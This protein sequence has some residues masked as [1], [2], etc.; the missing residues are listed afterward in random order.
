MLAAGALPS[1]AEGRDVVLV[2]MTSSRPP[3]ASRSTSSKN[4]TKSAA[5]ANRPSLPYLEEE[6]VRR[7]EERVLL[8]HP[9]P[10]REL[11]RRN[12]ERVL[13]RHPWPRRKYSPHW[14]RCGTRS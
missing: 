8:R 2:G 6:L 4:P 1:L 11:V 12:E 3:G 13:L 5:R 14:R 9:W 7:N 10:R